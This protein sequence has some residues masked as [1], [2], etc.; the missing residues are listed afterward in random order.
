MPYKDIMMQ[1]ANSSSWYYENK[2][3]INEERNTKFECACGG[4]YTKRGQAT[5]WKSKKHIKWLEHFEISEKM[6]KMTMTE[7]TVK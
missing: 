3:R 6:N 1:R 4:K 2:D 7:Y 5:H